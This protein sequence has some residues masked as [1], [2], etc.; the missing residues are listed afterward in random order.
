MPLPAARAAAA[1]ALGPSI[2]TT[3]SHPANATPLTLP[4]LSPPGTYILSR[5]Q[6]GD[7]S[8]QAPAAAQAQPAGAGERAKHRRTTEVVF[9]GVVLKDD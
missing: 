3:R 5:A 2:P 6:A 4:T 8:T 9:D 7:Y 1:R